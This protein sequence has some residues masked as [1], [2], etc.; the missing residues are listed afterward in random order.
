MNS[1]YIKEISAEDTF[2]VRHPVLR[3]GKPIRSCRFD[4]DD[5]PSTVHFGLYDASG[6]AGVASLYSAK[7]DLFSEDAQVQL[8]GMAVLDQHQKK[9]YGKMLL[10]HSEQ[11]AANNHADVMWFN[12]RQNAVGFYEKAGY[13]KLGE[14][15]DIADVGVHYV[16]FKKL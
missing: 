15:F 6:L 9:G 1:V 4:G 3:G 12:A 7:Q 16:M 13:I 14:P 5:L 8:R 10:L 2:A 11:Y